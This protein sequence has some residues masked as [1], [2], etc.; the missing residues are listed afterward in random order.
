MSLVCTA[1]PRANPADIDD[2]NRVGG[3]FHVEFAQ[4]RRKQP[5]AP[6]A[7]GANCR[8][9]IVPVSLEWAPDEVKDDQPWKRPPPDG[10]KDKTTLTRAPRPLSQP[11]PLPPRSRLLVLGSWLTRRPRRALPQSARWRA[12]PRWTSRRTRTSCSRA[13]SRRSSA[14]SGS[15]A[16]L[17]PRARAASRHR[18]GWANSLPC[19]APALAPRAPRSP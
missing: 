5:R 3:P 2:V 17:G 18:R 6:D 19:P 4:A 12:A 16:P 9:R 13:R 10:S 15:T 14:S 11:P 7:K 8:R 1:S